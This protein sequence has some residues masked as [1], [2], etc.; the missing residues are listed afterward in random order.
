MTQKMHSSA[1]SLARA[2]DNISINYKHIQCRL[3]KRDNCMNLH[4]RDTPL[5]NHSRFLFASKY[6]NK[7]DAVGGLNAFTYRREF[8]QL[9]SGLQWPRGI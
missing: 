9:N 8:A 4:K 3:Y 6:T 2:S 5:Q 7:T 1:Q